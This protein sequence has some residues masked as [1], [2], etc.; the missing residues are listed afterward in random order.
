MNAYEQSVCIGQRNWPELEE[1]EK[2]NYKGWVPIFDAELN[3]VALV[4][5]EKADTICEILN[6]FEPDTPVDYDENNNPIW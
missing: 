2:S 1:L 3:V 5:K 4:P 6:R